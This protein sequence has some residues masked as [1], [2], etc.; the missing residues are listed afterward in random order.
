MKKI[1]KVIAVFLALI[2]FVSSVP[3]SAVGVIKETTDIGSETYTYWDKSVAGNEAVRSTGMY[4]FYKTFYNEDFAGVDIKSYV[5]ITIDNDNNI[6]LLD[7]EASSIH[8]FDKSYNYLRSFAT[9]TGP[10]GTVYDYKGARGIVISN[11][12]VIYIC[13]T[14][15][16]RILLVDT[17][18]NL[19]SVL[20]LP[21]SGLIPTDFKFRPSKVAVDS[22]NYIYVLSEGSFYGAILYSPKG[23]FLGFFGA[24]TVAASVLDFLQTIWEKLT[25]TDAKKEAA[26]KKI[27]YQFTDL[28][29]DKQDFVYTV[30]G[31]TTK[32][33]E[34]GQIKR[35]SP[36]G[37]NILNSADTTFGL[38]SS[39]PMRNDTRYP[40]IAG[41]AVSSDNYIF[42]FDVN[43]GFI[44][45]FNDDCKM[46]NS[47][48][49][50]ATA[51]SSNLSGFQDGT[52]QN[53]TSI[54]IMDNKDI[55]ILDDTKK[56]ITVYKINDYGKL[57]IEADTLTRNGDYEKAHP[58]WNE[59]L[60][61]DRNSQ[62]AYSGI[63]KT[64]YAAGD[65]K[66]AMEY[67]KIGYDYNTYSL[68]Y[69]FVRRDIIERYVYVFAAII[70][71]IV[72]ALVIFTNYKRK[73]N[74]VII[75]NNELKLISRVML[76]PS[77]VFTEIKEKKSGSVGLGLILIILFYITSTLKETTSGFLFKSPTNTGFNSLL[78]LMQSLGLVL[79]WTICNWA[80]CT[81]MNGKGKMREIFIVASYSVIP[82]II[83]NI[84][85]SI[86]SNL[87]LESEAAFL[88]IFV[89]VMQLFMAFIL[90][91]G[92]LIVHD[93]GFGKFVG[94]TILSAL[95]ILIVIFLGIVVVILVQQ[96]G[97]FVG[98]VYREIVFL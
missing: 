15:N 23:E 94:T 85:Y 6:Y 72:V 59:I 11:D 89:T 19:I 46:L 55:V 33:V 39:I 42:S 28:Y 75:K 64:F 1:T 17:N 56:C 71:V 31:R 20:Y 34:K 12:N 98:T 30:T 21:E 9:I 58:L 87:I 37:L 92:T 82:L 18:G 53:I 65:Y 38:R 60:T 79:L 93:Y 57:V 22:S 24:N 70:L 32:S 62:V 36:G 35:L 96:L 80:V 45:V 27:P 7:N 83:S 54:D 16:A 63:A 29:I 52:F 25:M 44:S 13:D 43:S 76:H 97:N 40:D 10:D 77:E 41:L 95:G 5:D 2:L 14:E 68:S 81:L 50:G 74:I 90:I 84:V 69:D 78:V 8:I 47:F 49:G 26:I 66:Q 51:L 91:S 48:G 88:S 73:H 61:K 4:T 67:A 86:A 3:A